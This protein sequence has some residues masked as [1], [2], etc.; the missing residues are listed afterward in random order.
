M[1]AR[2]AVGA[3]IAGAI[4]LAVLWGNI[5]SYGHVTLAPYGQMAE[6]S[7]IGHRFAGRGPTMINENEP[8]AGR[9]FLRE[10][11][12]EEPSDLRVRQDLLRNGGELQEGEYADLDQFQMA[13][14]FSYRTIVTRTSPTA[15]RPP[16]AFRLVWTGTW[17][18]VWTRS[19]GSHPG[20]AERPVVD[21]LPLGTQFDPAGVPDCSQVARLAQE[22]G[23]KGALAVVARVPPT[24]ISLPAELPSGATK[25]RFQITTPGEYVIWLGGSIVGHLVT[26]VDGQQIG[27]THETLNE[28]GGYTPLGRIRLGPG[29]HRVVLRYTGTSLAPGSGGPGNANDPFTTGALEISPPP[30]KVPVTYVS[31]SHYRALCGKPW[32]WVE[33]LGP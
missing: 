15:S 26:A 13:T 23:P 27:S 19:G 21:S 7:Y 33:A 4:G 18:Q 25:E 8:Y 16:A 5:L 12:P 17:Y 14:L 1:P 24:G 3:T 10:M 22:A 11:D 30:G 32:D 9:H 31:P 29:S 20:Q 2:R 6:L 28:A